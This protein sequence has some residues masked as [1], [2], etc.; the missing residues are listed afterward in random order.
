MLL[1]TVQDEQAEYFNNEYFSVRENYVY[2][3]CDDGEVCHI[4]QHSPVSAGR[5]NVVTFISHIFHRDKR[6]K[7]CRL[8]KEFKESKLG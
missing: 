4:L 7:N 5:N 3:L 2:K 6:C 8:L 1:E